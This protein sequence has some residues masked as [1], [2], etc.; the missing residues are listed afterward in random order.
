MD[1]LRDEEMKAGAVWTNS[2]LKVW[3]LTRFGG[4]RLHQLRQLPKV[5]GRKRQTSYLL[6]PPK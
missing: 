2:R 1:F 5:L 3:W 6:I 4:Y